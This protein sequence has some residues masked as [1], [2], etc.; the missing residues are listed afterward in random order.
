M[1]SG[2]EKLI[3]PS[4]STGRRS[5]QMPPPEWVSARK[6]TKLMVE[7]KKIWLKKNGI[8]DEK[9]GES[10]D[11]RKTTTSPSLRCRQIFRKWS[12]ICVDDFIL[13]FLPSVFPGER[14]WHSI[15]FFQKPIAKKQCRKKSPAFVSS[16]ATFF[17]ASTLNI[18]QFY[19]RKN[20]FVT[21]GPFQKSFA[22]M[23]WSDKVAVD[24]KASVRS[25]ARKTNKQCLIINRD[26]CKVIN[27]LFRSK[28]SKLLEKNC[29]VQ[30]LFQLG[31]FDMS[32]Y[33]WKLDKK[34]RHFFIGCF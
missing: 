31:D 28:K 8:A 9:L 23:T 18:T 21:I 22:S 2:Y 17:W 15:C 20:V 5:A 24:Q 25:F 26:V 1:L 34:D 11:P 19:K 7:I 6:K 32:I 30:N 3:K 29:N 16:G 13:K 27:I 4:S 14:R 10:N 33:S 12:V